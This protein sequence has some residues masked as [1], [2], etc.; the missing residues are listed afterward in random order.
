MFP[1]I[2]GPALLVMAVLSAGCAQLGIKS[3]PWW[4]S[5]DVHDVQTMDFLRRTP[6]VDAILGEGLSL[7]D[8]DDDERLVGLSVSG[9][10]ARAAAFT[11]GVLTGIEELGNNRAAALRQ[12]SPLDK[13]DFISSN[14]GGSWAVAAYVV[15]RAKR[16]DRYYSVREAVSE[17]L[18]LAFVKMSRG[19]VPCWSRAMREHLFGRSTFRNVYSASNPVPL[20]RVYL[21]A[22]LM[23]AHSP[24]V[25]TDAFLSYYQVKHFGAC[26][27]DWTP[28]VNRIADVPIAFAASASGTVPGFYTAFATTGLCKE[29][30]HLR[31]SSFCH[32]T[33]KGGPRSFLR[34]SDG[35]LYDNIAYKTAYEVM[36]SER[37]RSPGIRKS[38]ILVNSGTSADLQTVSEKDLRKSFLATTAMNGVFAVQD[39][40]FQRL[41]SRMF[42]SVGVDKTVLLDFYSLAKFPTGKDALLDGLDELAFFAAHNVDCYVGDTLQRSGGKALP[43]VVPSARQ[44]F[45]HLK[46]RGGDCASENFYRVGNLSKTTFLADHELFT[47]MWQLG[48]LAVRMNE[49]EV[50]AATAT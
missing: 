21:N 20:P 44:S 39:S 41:Y 19:R 34:I 31:E 22:A 36:L 3:I 14:S 11:L 30:S 4:Q 6:S 18:G 32:A 33:Q 10:G 16:K 15:D 38:M 23:P 49:R 9:G 47:I 5:T 12:S 35:G 28:P 50:R 37:G 48:Q 1:K 40:T 17:R 29:D 42:E 8:M 46:Q 24:F 25:F 27:N 2:A 43:A 45:H 26:W 13:L 7:K